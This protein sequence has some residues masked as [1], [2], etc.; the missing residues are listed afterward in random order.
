MTPTEL[1]RAVQNRLK[2][3]WVTDVTSAEPTD[4]WPHRFPTGLAAVP[5]DDLQARWA[6]VHQP[7]VHM[8]RD[9]AHDHELAVIDKPRRVWVIQDLPTHIEISNIDEAARLVAGEWPDRLTRARQ[10]IDVLRQRFPACDHA[11]VIRAVDDY[12]DIDFDLLLTVAD[13]YLQDPTRA[14]SGVTPR[15]VPLPGVHAKWLQARTAGVLAL[16]GLDTLGLLPRHPARIH[17]TYLDPDHRAAGHRWHDS[18]TVGDAFKPAYQPTVV[19]I[20]EN[21]D[22]AI[23]FPPISGGVA[24]EGDGFG[25]KTAAAFP[26]LAE[27]PRLFY[28]GDVDAHGYEIL[29]GY[30]ADGLPVTSILMDAATYKA[31]E[32]Y[33]TNT[34]KY[35]VPLK[36]GSP[37]PLLHLTDAERTVY[38]TVLDPANT[39]HRRI[40]QE[41]IPLQDASA[42][43]NLATT[44]A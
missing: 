5:Q 25:G 18:A 3:R 26:W 24:V 22:T 43:L 23:H 36:P 37:K 4:S 8:W 20:S 9:W 33:G 29:N 15:Q 10:R 11:A 2:A 14:A 42:A 39:G 32:P 31:Y 38:E 19:L 34:D 27:A 16:T 21:K 1:I 17:F 35:N 44:G 12:T 40:E 7:S 28:W 30:R 41:R 13:W 6:D